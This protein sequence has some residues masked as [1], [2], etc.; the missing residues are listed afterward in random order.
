MRA[1]IVFCLVLLFVGMNSYAQ[2]KVN[3][4]PKKILIAYFSW[5][6]NTKHVAEHIADLTGGTLF[7]IEP[8][9]SY[10]TEYTHVPRLQKLKRKPTPGLP[11]KIRLKSGRSM[12]LYLSDAPSGGGLLQ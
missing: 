1:K 6:G 4:T 9:K 2:E 8:E 12:T 7:R 5:G 10:P 3:D 11:S